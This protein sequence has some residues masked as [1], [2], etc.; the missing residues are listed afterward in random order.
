MI[1]LTTNVTK[2]SSWTQIKANDA[3]PPVGSKEPASQ[4]VKYADL[5]DQDK[6]LRNQI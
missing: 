6:A 5:E 2:R 4:G 3:F 1:N